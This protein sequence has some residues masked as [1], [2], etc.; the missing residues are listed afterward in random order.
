MLNSF[1][2]SGLILLAAALL[3]CQCTAVK[4]QPSQLDANHFSASDG[5]Q[6][7]YTRWPDASKPAPAPLKALV[8]CVHGLSGAA[9]DFWP[10][11]D[12]LSTQ[13]ILVYG[14]QLRGMG[15]D[16]EK[17]QHGNVSSAQRWQQDLL[18]FTQLLHAQHPTLPIYWYGESLGSLIVIHSLA[19]LGETQQLVAGVIL[20]SP[21]IAFRHDLPAWKYWPIRFLCAVWPGKRISLESLGDR[22]VKVTNST[23]HKQQMEHTPH[24]VEFFTLR[25]FRAVDKMVRTSD[26]AASKVTL[27]TLL[28]YTPNDVFTSAAQVE[29]FYRPIPATDKQKICYPDSYHLILHDVDRPNVL[30]AL[31]QWMKARVK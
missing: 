16:P 7:P 15:N 18:E 17:P 25:L 12:L 5:K 10:A 1:P 31:E 9:S 13:E 30:K 26:A 21:V 23:T 28:F 8:I 24:Y 22:E 11:G 6:M 29:A 27:P 19:K 20:S 14:M 4:P 3:L 2:F